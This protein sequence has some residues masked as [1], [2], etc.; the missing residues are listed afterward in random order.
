MD[1]HNA[2][3]QKEYALR[4]KDKIKEYQKEWRKKNQDSIM[5]YQGKYRSEHREKMREYLRKYQKDRLKRDVQFRLRYSLRVRIRIALH[6]KGKSKRSFDLIGC[7]IKELKQ[8]IEKQFQTGMTWENWGRYG[9]HIDH[10]RPCARF[11][12][13]DPEQQ[14]KC[15]HYSNLQPLWAEENQ[16]KNCKSKEISA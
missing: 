11:D 15:F 13:S 6:G 12:L 5:V 8:H 3:K 10:I 14:R 4:N 2:Q 16:K 9:W 7:T 1:E